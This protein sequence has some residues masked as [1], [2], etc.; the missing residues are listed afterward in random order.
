MKWISGLLIILTL[1][2]LTSCGETH[3][4]S[5]IIIVTDKGH[6]EDNKEYWIAAYNPNNEGKADTFRIIVEE[7][8]VWNLIEEDKEYFSTYAKEGESPWLLEQIEFV[9]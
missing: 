2:P 4:T 7:V 6:S 1:L 9:K 8:M 3:S 5:S